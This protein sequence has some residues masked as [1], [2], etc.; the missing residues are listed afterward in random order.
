[1][2]IVMV[3]AAA[4]GA[5]AQ[6]NAGPPPPPPPPPPP[7][8]T[9]TPTPTAT[10]TTPDAPPA[11]AG[12]AITPLGWY[13][14]GGIACSAVMPIAGTIILR[15]EM[16]AAEVGR[17]T[18]GCFLGPVGWVL[19]PMLF[20]D[21]SVTAAGPPQGPRPPRA[22]RQGGNRNV[23]IPPASETRFVRNEIL[24]QVDASLSEQ[25]LA[26][27]A[28]RLQLTRLETQTF[29]L[30]SRTL[31]RWRI[32]GDRSVAQTLRLL[33]RYRGIVA[34]QPNYLYGLTQT[35][36]AAPTDASAQYV[37]GKLRLT[38]AH[39]VTNGDNV[40][41]AVVDS[42][43]DTQHPDLAGVIAGEY[44]ALGGTSKPHAHG[45]AMA[46]AI[47]AHSKLIGVAPK[48]RLL[49]VRTFAGEGESAQGTTFN[50]LK[51][52]DWAAAQGARIVNMS[53]AGPPDALLRELLAKANGRGI[54]LIA[55]VGNDGPRSPPL[56]PAA[57]RGVIGVTATDA[58]DKLLPQANRGSQVAVA[59]PGV[60]VLAAAPDG[61][62]A[63]T[64]GTSVAAAH[65]SGVA[66]LLLAVKPD[67]T[68]AALRQALV[69]SARR[70]PGKPAEIGAG[71]IDALDA[72]NAT[73]R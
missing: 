59:A 64:S 33:A 45:T 10:T 70:V 13:V 30:T 27:I 57:D 50:I 3:T 54:V 41:V 20:P 63:M 66:A 22:T 29:T 48:V 42:R 7:V 24:L 2:A 4:G 43:V 40:L 44:D 53:F 67:L 51:G 56:Y 18:L 26:R 38:E 69:R 55:A 37:V 12:H 8:V 11:R 1:M 39:R 9:P 60:D 14:M 36:Q 71:V 46:G 61:E 23:S 19:G 72:V 52:I 25:A 73:Q 65:A 62:Y 17:S 49:V 6:L 28:A 16:T 47:A 31:Q 5:F 32:D 35:A 34:A 21:A 15:R 58:E 68:P